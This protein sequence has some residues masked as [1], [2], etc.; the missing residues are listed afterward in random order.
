M[1]SLTHCINSSHISLLRGYFCGHIES[2]SPIGQTI[3]SIRGRLSV[4][5]SLLSSENADQIP[6]VLKLVADTSGRYIFFMR[7]M[8]TEEPD[9]IF[10]LHDKHSS[11]LQGDLSGVE[12]LSVHLEFR[13]GYKKIVERFGSWGCHPVQ[14]TVGRSTND[15][16]ISEKHIHSL[17]I[18]RVSHS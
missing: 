6:A 9:Y 5:L 1:R 8:V 12:Q 18:L 15:T 14:V 13:V 3:E 16:Y 17:V 10:I 2:E 11:L 4:L 7:L